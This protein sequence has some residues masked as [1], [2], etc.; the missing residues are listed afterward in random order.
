MKPRPR[1]FAGARAAI[2]ALLALAGPFGGAAAAAAGMDRESLV[3]ALGFERRE[4]RAEAAAELAS[5]AADP[6]SAGELLSHP[7]RWVRAAAAGSLARK[8]GAEAVP[9]LVRALSTERDPLARGAMA[10]A[11]AATG[12]G[13]RGA[14][15]SACAALPREERDSVF[16]A[17]ARA[18]VER[19]MRRILD[20]ITDSTG[21]VK[22]F[23]AKPFAGIL[24]LRD[25]AVPV[26]VEYVRSGRT[27]VLG[28][29]VAVR[30]LAEMGDASAVGPLR[31]VFDSLSG[32]MRASRV[33]EELVPEIGEDSPDEVELRRYVSHALFRLG[34]EEPF[35]IRMR[36]F[37]ADLAA[38]LREPSWKS[39]EI[40]QMRGFYA[41][42][43]EHHQVR[44]WD[45]AI[46][47]YRQAKAVRG[48][49]GFAGALPWDYLASYNMACIEAQRGDVALAISHLAEAIDDGFADFDW[50]SR[51]PDLDPLRS[52]PRFRAL[53][54]DARD[55][56]PRPR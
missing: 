12:A 40:D 4:A 6:A 26:L 23:Y 11:L 7:S 44:Q 51:D 31:E 30:G 25:E 24:D 45:D 3:R 28:R 34:D 19:E 9:A 1:P 48:L 16:S 21:A 10:A 20:E 14:V 27:S 2:L 53:T 35:D 22:G 38:L 46:A 41:I 29:Q 18:A 32:W 39:P 43:Y 5:A 49:R 52:D 55:E 33:E 15:R 37:F 42:G 47:Y 13:S 17:Y 54:G 8:P 56:E 36:K 50:I